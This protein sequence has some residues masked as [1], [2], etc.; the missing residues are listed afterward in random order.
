MIYARSNAVTDPDMLPRIPAWVTAAH[1]E[2][3]ED[4]AFCRARH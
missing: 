1:V 3:L 2:T 4:V